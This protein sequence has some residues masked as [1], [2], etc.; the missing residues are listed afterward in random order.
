[1]RGKSL[2]SI[3]SVKRKVKSKVANKSWNPNLP[4]PLR[5][6]LTGYN[7]P[8]L[9]TMLGRNF[10]ILTKLKK[11]AR[12]ALV[13]ALRSPATAPAPSTLIMA[14]GAVNPS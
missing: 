10:W 11:E 13:F 12:D 9:N 5:L 8:S 7:T 14:Q 4:Y 6:T 1:M 3:A 2:T